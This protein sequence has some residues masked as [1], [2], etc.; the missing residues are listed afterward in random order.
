MRTVIQILDFHR[1][2]VIRSKRTRNNLPLFSS[3]YFNCYLCESGFSSFQQGL[4]WIHSMQTTPACAYIPKLTE[5]ITMV[6]FVLYSSMQWRLEHF[7][8]VSFTYTEISLNG[9]YIKF[10]QQ[11]FLQTQLVHPVVVNLLL[12]SDHLK[13][14]LSCHFALFGDDIK[15]DKL[16]LGF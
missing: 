14:C 6:D 11:T 4:E 13:K 1:S 2:K 8:F 5:Q 10:L 15:Y 9:E 16:D 3:L 7:L 12:M